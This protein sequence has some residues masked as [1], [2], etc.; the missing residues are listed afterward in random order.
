MKSELNFVL[1][2]EILTRFWAKVDK[3]EPDTCWNWTAARSRK[4]GYGVFGLC[5]KTYR[6]HRISWLIHHGYMPDSKLDVCHKCDNPACVNP[7]HLFLGT[8]TDNMQDC[9]RKGRTS[10]VPRIV[11]TETR[12]AKL[13]DAAVAHLRSLPSDISVLREFALQYGMSYQSVLD[14]YRGKTWKHVE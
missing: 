13:N 8:R 2:Q 3:G 11:G 5:G 4:M 6:A 7:L 12:S 9:A 14:A 1:N 10:R